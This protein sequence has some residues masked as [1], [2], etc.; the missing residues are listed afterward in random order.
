MQ[1]YMHIR[2]K[3]NSVHA[4]ILVSLNSDASIRAQHRNSTCIILVQLLCT[5]RAWMYSML[6]S[7]C[8]SNNACMPR[9]SAGLHA[10]IRKSE[11]TAT[12]LR[13]CPQA[14]VWP[15]VQ[16]CVCT[17]PAPCRISGVAYV[18]AC[19]HACVNVVPLMALWPA[20][21]RIGSCS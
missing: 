3:S 18:Q 21:I 20:Q 12:T 13:T 6:P 11:D 15:Y 14:H 5:T 9:C 8:I 4:T 1:H 16:Q 17:S 19:M 10:C 7:P 2:I